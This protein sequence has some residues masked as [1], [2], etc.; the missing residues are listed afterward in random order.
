MAA[1]FE[2]CELWNTIPISIYTNGQIPVLIFV[3]SG[4]DIL[5]SPSMGFQ[6]QIGKKP[7]GNMACSCGES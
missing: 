5:V 1:S 3:R 2:H 4:P 6:A 7:K